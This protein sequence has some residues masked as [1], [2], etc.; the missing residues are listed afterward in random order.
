ME[1]NE[2]LR[3]LLRDPHEPDGKRLPIRI[4]IGA[5]L[6]PE[7][8]RDAAECSGVPKSRC[9]VPR[10]RDGIVCYF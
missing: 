10:M 3:E 8:D 2:R 5:A 4:S 1:P 7:H 6:Y 9:I